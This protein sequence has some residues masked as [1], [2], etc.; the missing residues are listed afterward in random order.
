MQVVVLAGGLGTRLRPLT[1]KHPKALIDVSG[2]PFLEYQ[3]NWLSRHSLRD[4]VLCVGYLGEKVE[5]FAK[6]GSDFGA[7]IK[8]SRE[9]DKLLGTAGALK[10]AEH[11]LK[12]DFCVLNG[13]SYLPINP[14]DPIRHFRQ[15]GFTAMMLTLRNRN[16]YDR[17]NVM[18]HNDRVTIY[19]RNRPGLELIDYGM[20]IFK[21]EVLQFVPLD[22][23][24]NLDFLYQR[25]IEKKNLMAYMVSKPFY[26]VGSA[27]GLAR[28]KQYVREEKLYKQ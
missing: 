23:F 5:A 9:K 17:S 18:V 22:S 27:R 24:C 28:F 3:L 15:A 6:D 21:R 10:S 19:D 11:M 16:R 12:E 20:Q 26:E 4:I 13:D 7:R 2:K 25:L 8:Y 14:L 1:N